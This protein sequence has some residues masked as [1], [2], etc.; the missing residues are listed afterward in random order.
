MENQ[1]K[2]LLINPKF[3]LSLLG[4]F[5]ALSLASLTIFYGSVYYFF[6]KFYTMG[7]ELA[8]CAF[9]DGESSTRFKHDKLNVLGS[10]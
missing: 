2:V 5:M 7:S 4:Y 1:R 3:Q 10:V 8:L 9:G 6:S